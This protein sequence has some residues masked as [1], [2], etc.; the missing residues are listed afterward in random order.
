MNKKNILVVDDEADIRNLL[1]IFL[2]QKGYR[3]TTA[4]NGNEALTEASIEKPS[5]ILLDILMPGMDGLEICTALKKNPS[6]ARIPIV[7]CSVLAMEEDRAKAYE[8]GAAS[9]LTKPFNLQAVGRVV[10]DIVKT[11]GGVGWK[12]LDP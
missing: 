7:I 10:D 8:A 2:K 5:L 12:P 11:G 6:T 1:S 3:V 4:S 9:Y